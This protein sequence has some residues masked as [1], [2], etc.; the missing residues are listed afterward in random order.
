MGWDPGSEIRDPE[1][2]YSGSR[3]QKGTGSRIPDPDPQHWSPI[4]KAYE[5]KSKL[6]FFLSCYCREKPSS[7]PKHLVSQLFSISAPKLN[8]YNIRFL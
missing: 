8:K 2:T 3:G 1:K 7:G 4:T 6:L 5:K